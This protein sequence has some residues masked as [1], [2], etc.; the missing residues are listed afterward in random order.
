MLFVDFLKKIKSLFLCSIT[1]IVV[2]CIRD[3]SFCLNMR[4]FFILFVL[5][6]PYNHALRWNLCPYSIA[7]SLLSV[8]HTCSS[9]YETKAISFEWFNKRKTV[10]TYIAVCDLF[11]FSFL[12]F[13][14]R[15]SV[16]HIKEVFSCWATWFY[17]YVSYNHL[18]GFWSSY[19]LYG[20]T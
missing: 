9:H 18:G 13:S 7:Y 10:I 1:W 4:V 17:F 14:F 15:V 3:C 8:F 20:W 16:I 2:L 6:F 12:S 11:W 5:N 19:N